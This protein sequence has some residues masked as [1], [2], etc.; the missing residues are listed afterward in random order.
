MIRSMLILALLFGCTPP[1]NEAAEPIWG[2]QACDHCMMLLSEPR[3]AAQLVS[4]DN[5]RHFFD[6]VG[7]MVE[8]LEQHGGDARAAWI[9]SPHGAGW[10]D[11]FSARYA[12]GQRTPMDYGFL[13]A[14]SGLSFAEVRQA[15]HTKAAA[16]AV[17]R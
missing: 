12:A 16:R 11:A 17:Q 1:P 14:A 5:T 8:W 7:C 9:R 3:P 10:Q 15:I 2:K 6:D 13:P 4:S